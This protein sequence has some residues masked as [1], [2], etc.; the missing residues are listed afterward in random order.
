MVILSENKVGID[1]KTVGMYCLMHCF[2]YVYSTSSGNV[3]VI[4]LPYLMRV[5]AAF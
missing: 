1:V 5:H 3:D 2:A 4:F